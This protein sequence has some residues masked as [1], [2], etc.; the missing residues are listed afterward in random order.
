[1]FE[2]YQKRYEMVE[3]LSM[4]V[5]WQLKRQYVG[6]STKKSLYLG[7]QAL[8]FKGSMHNAFGYLVTTIAARQVLTGTYSYPEDFDQA[9]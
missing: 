8:I 3:S 2:W 9:V 5:S 7:E 4:K 6:R 1:M